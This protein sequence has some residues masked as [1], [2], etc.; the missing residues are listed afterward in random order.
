M[1]DREIWKPVIGVDGLYSVSSEGRVKRNSSNRI[2]SQFKVGG[3]SVK[4]MAVAMRVNGAHDQRRVHRMVL[5]SFVGPCPDGMAGA[6]GDGNSQNN[7]LSNLRW[8]TPKENSDDMRDHGTRAMGSRHGYS[9]LNESDILA[10]R[11][12]IVGGE[13][14][15]S[16]A[17]DYGVSISTIHC[18]RH[19]R[20]W[21]HV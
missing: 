8:A 15:R 19:N 13:K 18:I 5:E 6:H 3:G 20:T 11:N 12:R 7:K 14:N 17:K 4:Y 10:I 9:K 1:D 2:L 21:K 16:I